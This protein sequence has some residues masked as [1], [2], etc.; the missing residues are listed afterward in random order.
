MTPT[1]RT[2]K[3]AR[4]G[5]CC[6]SC[7]NHS[8]PSAFLCF[9]AVL[10]SAQELHLWQLGNLD[11]DML[12]ADA[13]T[14]LNSHTHSGAHAPASSSSSAAAASSSLLSSS[15]LSSSSLLPSP[16]GYSVPTLIRRYAGHHANRYMVR[17][18]FGGPSGHVLL[19]GSEDGLLYCYHR[20]S[21]KLLKSLRGHTATINNV[22]ATKHESKY[23]FASASD[24]KTIKVWAATHVTH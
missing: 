15:S 7:L 12:D 4:T 10:P 3:C 20:D 1:Q 5:A 9:F 23:I 19:C 18:C 16:C 14:P 8:F 11:A 6:A 21:G 22:A 2:E 17:S 13:S 24:D